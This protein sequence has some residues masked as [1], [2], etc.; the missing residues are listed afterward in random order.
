MNNTDILEE[1]FILIKQLKE[2]LELKNKCLS[3]ISHDFKGMFSNIL[4][5]LEAYESEVIT[6][7][8]FKSMLPEIKQNAQI[9]RNTINDTFDWINVQSG[10]LTLQPKVIAVYEVISELLDLLQSSIKKKNISFKYNGDKD[11]LI[12]CDKVILR[13][14]IRKVMENAIKYSYFNGEIELKVRLKDELISISILDK[15]IGISPEL[16]ATMFTL[17][18]PIYTGTENEKGV[19]LSMVIVNKFV[20]MMNGEIEVHPNH[21]NGTIVELKFP[22]SEQNGEVK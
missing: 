9:N 13:F 8:E 11:L 3:L 10:T 21:G 17:N 5:V 16:S 4:W 1:Q 2:E 22:I 19:G 7:Q 18:G 14:I 12:Y 15:G 6:E 20:Q